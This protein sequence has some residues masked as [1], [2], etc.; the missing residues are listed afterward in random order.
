MAQPL[1]K[2]KEDDGTLYTRFPEI[3]AAADVALGH[4]LDRLGRR[5]TI[6]DRKSRDYLPSECLVHLIRDAHRRDDESR[7][8][9]L[10]VALLER[11]HAI[12]N[13]K[14]DGDLPNAIMLRKQ[15]LNDFAALFAVDGS[16]DDKL[17]LDYFEV[18][19]NHA[20]QRFRISRLRPVLALLEKET[21]IPEHAGETVEGELDNEVLAR[22][23]T[24]QDSAANPE[25]RVFR[26]QVMR[27]INALP[28]D[29]R[30]ALVLVHYYGFKIESED[31]GETTAATLCSVRGRTI[32]NRLNR[33]K[34]KLS[35][36]K[37]VS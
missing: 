17:G 37:E 1:K 9:R 22:L 4:D 19:F 15:I 29:E 7:R 2:I 24:L 8:D 6:W 5:A 23:A 35:K 21:E 11:C 27:A 25:E 14:V 26:N 13:K 28:P 34:A 16:P 18:R 20:F 30:K 3:E 33:A 10:L 32:Q 31:P 36:L 12:L